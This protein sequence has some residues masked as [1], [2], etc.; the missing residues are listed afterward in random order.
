MMIYSQDILPMN[1]DDGFS[2]RDFTQMFRL[3]CD[4]RFLQ[5]L[6]DLTKP[7]GLPVDVALMARQ[8]RVTTAP[9]HVFFSGEV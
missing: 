9:H 4:F 3:I 2:L 8:L 6:H 5:P 7:R 1:I